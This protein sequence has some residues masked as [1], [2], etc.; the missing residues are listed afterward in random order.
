[1]N[2]KSEMVA[3]GN[4]GKETQSVDS[5]TLTISNIIAKWEKYASHTKDRLEK[6]TATKPNLYE[7]ISSYINLIE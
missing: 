5:E 4:S 7:N 2:Q 6:K 3:D 1:M